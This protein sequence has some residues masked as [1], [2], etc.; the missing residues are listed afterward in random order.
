MSALKATKE[1]LFAAFSVSTAAFF[2][3]QKTLQVK[4]CTSLA[5]PLLILNRYETKRLCQIWGMPI[6]PD[7][8]NEELL[9]SRNRVRK[10]LMPMLRSFFNPK[11][12]LVLAHLSEA[13]LLEQ[14]CTEFHFV[15]VNRTVK[16][17]H[18]L[19]P[20]YTILRFW[21]PRPIVR[22]HHAEIDL[23]YAFDRP[24]GEVAREPN[25]PVGGRPPTAYKFSTHRN[26]TLHNKL[27]SRNIPFGRLGVFCVQSSFKGER[28]SQFETPDR[29][30]W[31]CCKIQKNRSL[32][33][34]SIQAC[35]NALSIQMVSQPNETHF[36]KHR[37]L[38]SEIN[39]R[40]REKT[41]LS[42]YCAEQIFVDCSLLNY[43]GIPSCQLDKNWLWG[44]SLRHQYCYFP[45]VGCLIKSGKTL[46]LRRSP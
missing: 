20:T 13:L 28:L 32:S 43:E 41:A 16:Y 36:N 3:S 11:I 17:C 46:P 39:Y 37:I 22:Q 24:R 7:K 29:E 35:R 25:L 45:K 19:C 9:F 18:L 33:D 10:Q 14:L 30:W 5:R 21:Q 42:M 26:T 44:V 27:P 34:L 4:K 38:G 12:D 8:T 1:K 23:P 15:K 31:L 6:Y 2:V 40:L